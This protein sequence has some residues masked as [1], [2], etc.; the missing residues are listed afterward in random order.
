MPGEAVARI[1]FRNEELLVGEFWC[2]PQSARWRTLNRVSPAAHV[3]FPRTRVAIRQVGRET[4]LADRNLVIF[5][6]PGQR[7]FRTLRD[8]HGDHCYFVEVSRGRGPRSPATRARRSC[9][10][11]SARAI[12]PCT[13]SSTPR[14]PICASSG[15]T[16]WSWRRT[17]RRPWPGRLRM[18][19]PFTVGGPRR[20]G[21]RPGGPSQPRGRGEGAPWR[22]AR[23]AAHAG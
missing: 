15:V 18:H 8:A 13:C 14:S 23:R 19:A 6:N 12:R 7:F 17:W 3:V 21:G 4:V 10:S 20:V 5:Y 11:P 1:L 16:H 22:A 2:P 9:R